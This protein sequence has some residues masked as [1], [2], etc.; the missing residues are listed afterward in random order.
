VRIPS[1]TLGRFWS[2][3]AHVHGQTLNWSELGRSM[4]VGDNTVRHYVDVL[5]QAFVVRALLPWHQN[6]SKRQVKSPKVWVADSGLLHTLLDLESLPA[7]ERHP[8][9]GASFEGH[10]IDQVVSHLA[11]RPEQCFFWA[12]QAGAELDLLVVQGNARRGFE[13]KY[14]DAPA[15]TPSMR[16]ALADLKL[17]SLDVLYPGTRTYSLHHRVR[18]VPISRLLRDVVR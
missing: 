4:G 11:A 1:A 18:A 16:I 9:L 10:C 2:I 15:L 7:L 3:L 5:A 12:T 14:S 8:K 6:L 17:D 13:I